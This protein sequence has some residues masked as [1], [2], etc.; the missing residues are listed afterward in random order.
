MLYQ[1]NSWLEI[2][3]L[4]YTKNLYD[5]KHW[6]IDIDD[7]L[8]T[9]KSHKGSSDWFYDKLQLCETYR[10][11]R[12]LIVKWESLQKKLDYKLCNNHVVLFLKRIKGDKSLITAR[13]RSVLSETYM[14][15]NKTNI[16]NRLYKNIYF[17]GSEKKSEIVKKE[18]PY[19]TNYQELYVFL[20]DKLSNVLDMHENFPNMICIHLK[21]KKNK[22]SLSRYVSQKMYD[23]FFKCL[24]V[25]VLWTYSD[26][27]KKEAKAE[28]K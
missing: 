18:F 10:E 12:K 1:L 28:E 2:F 3:N 14:H 24:T 15:L 9:C 21:N 6:L 17:C 26:K 16:N 22:I 8:I 25:Y 5:S 27:N 20:D 19:M 11:R 23:Y 4:A 7:T 13:H